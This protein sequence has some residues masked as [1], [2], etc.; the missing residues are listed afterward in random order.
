MKLKKN[1][2][3]AIQRG[4]TLVELV[5]GIAIL[6]VLASLGIPE[7]RSV[8]VRNRTQSAASD[9][10]SALAL[11]RSEAIKRGGDARMTIVANNKVGNNA[12]W[13]SGT[14]VFVD[15]T[16]NAN[17]AT[18]IGDVSKIVF[19]SESLSSDVEVSSNLTYVI[20]NG[21]GRTISANGAPQ[22]GTIAF[23]AQG[24]NWHC[25]VISLSGRPRRFVQ[26]ADAYAAVGCPVN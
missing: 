26:S 9:F 6:A 10:E 24:S 8:L 12:D 14:T 23:G 3:K 11:A 16:N 5:I 1:P 13:K 7:L 25:V 2:L 20:Y 4:L 18:P 15:N 22:G 19:K 17:N 21:L